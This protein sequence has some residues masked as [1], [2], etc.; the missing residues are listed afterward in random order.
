MAKRIT[1]APT[2]EAAPLPPMGEGELVPGWTPEDEAAHAAAAVTEHAAAIAANVPQWTGR[3]RCG[4]CG[5]ERVDAPVPPTPI[6][7]APRYPCLA[8]CRSVLGGVTVARRSCV[9]VEG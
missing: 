1:P 5:H 3:V 7:L 8:G 2:G 6:D 4:L 9:Q